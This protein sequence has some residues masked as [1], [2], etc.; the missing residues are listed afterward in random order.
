MQPS[1]VSYQVSEVHEGERVMLVEVIQSIGKGNATFIDARTP[2]EYSGRV[3]VTRSLSESVTASR[4]GHIPGGVRIQPVR[5]WLAGPVGPDN[6]P[7]LKDPTKAESYLLTPTRP[8]SH[9]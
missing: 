1:P 8:T 5:G 7:A 2:D 9:R 6:L 3:A 4:S